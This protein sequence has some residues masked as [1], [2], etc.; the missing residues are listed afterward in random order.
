MTQRPHRTLNLDQSDRHQLH[1]KE[2][3]NFWLRKRNTVSRNIKFYIKK[4]LTDIYEQQ[5]FISG[6]VQLKKPC[7]H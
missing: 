5:C 7:A 4:K 2:K 1:K 6:K 3:R